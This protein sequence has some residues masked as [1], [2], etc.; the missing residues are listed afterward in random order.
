MA[1]M[2]KMFPFQPN[3]QTMPPTRAAISRTQILA[4]TF[5]YN[6]WNVHVFNCV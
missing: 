4:N 3:E 2:Q 1:H 6:P 5:H